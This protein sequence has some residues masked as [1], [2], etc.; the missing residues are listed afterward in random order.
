[1]K[2]T[3]NINKVGR[4]LFWLQYVIFAMALIAVLFFGDLM[5]E[6]GLKRLMLYVLYM[7][8]LPSVMSA[9][10]MLTVTDKK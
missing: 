9:L 2:K 3:N 10:V 6:F 4:W 8:G 5:K 7:S 1:M